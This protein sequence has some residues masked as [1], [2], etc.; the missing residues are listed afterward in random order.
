MLIKNLIYNLQTFRTRYLLFILLVFPLISEY[1]EDGHMPQNPRDWIT[2]IIMTTV[3]GIT[4]TI[5]Y[6]Q[7]LL[8]EKQSLLDHLTG[9]G[10]RRQLE[11]D[12]KREILRANRKNTGIMLIFFDLDGFKKINDTYG[13]E[14]GDKVLILFADGLSAFA[15]KGLDFCYRFGGDEFALLFTDINNTELSDIENKIEERLANAVYSKLPE[16]V[17]ASKGIVLLK[18]NE[19]Y[20]EVLKRADEAMYRIKREKQLNSKSG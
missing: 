19:N 18:E 15:R 20:I 9:I 6:R 12:V 5:I 8:L 16:G 7:H 14:A 1:L 3:M 4:V 17:S 2:E 10:N 13:H 11:Q